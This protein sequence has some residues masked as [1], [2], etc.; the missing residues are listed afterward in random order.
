MPRIEGPV[1]GEVGIRISAIGVNRSEITLRPGQ[2]PAKPPLPVV[3]NV[4]ML[5]LRIMF[6]LLATSLGFVVL[7]GQRTPSTVL[8]VPFEVRPDRVDRRSH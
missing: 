2:S 3:D 4:E 8:L 6:A 5:K 1:E 7:K